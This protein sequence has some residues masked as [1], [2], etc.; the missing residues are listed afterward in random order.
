MRVVT[1]V[2]YL[3]PPRYD[4]VAWTKAMI[5]EAPTIDGPWT[6]IDLVTFVAPDADPA[7]PDPRSFTTHS[8]QLID[9]WY[10]VTFIDAS[11]NDSAPTF[12]LRFTEDT[13]LPYLPALSDVGSIMRARTRDSTGAEKGTFTSDTRPTGS[14]MT[15]II[16]NAGR[17]VELK[18]GHKVPEEYLDDA[19]QLTKLRAAMLAELAY[20][21][22]QVES[23]TSP[24]SEYKA[25]YEQ[26]LATL[27]EALVDVEGDDSDVDSAGGMAI[28]S[29]PVDK[30]GL[31]GW[32]TVM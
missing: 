28:Y 2:D 3:P 27:V 17:D 7:H 9:G 4:N 5:E 31:V 16:R 10:R 22:E 11:G 1:F 14:E 15:T 18:I 23:R 21:P 13:S 26:A 24:Y 25:L 6:Q 12:P 29:F 20:W 19:K 32:D 8:A 30:G